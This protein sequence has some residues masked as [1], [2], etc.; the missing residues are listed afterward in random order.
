MGTLMT[1]FLVP[2]ADADEV[3][4]AL[5]DFDRYAAHTRIVHEVRVTAVRDRT[6]TR[7]TVEASWAVHFRGGLLCWS[8]RAHLDRLARTIR[9]AQTGGDFAAYQGDWGVRQ[10]GGDVTVRHAA[11]FDL[12]MPA[13][14]AVLEP[15]AERALRDNVDSVLRGLLGPDVVA[16]ELLPE[17]SPL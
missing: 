2:R 6:A 7:R 15:L 13:L 17:V 10:S 3:F 4:D 5:G 12:G 8:E 9:F 14:A 11:S 1:E 16:L